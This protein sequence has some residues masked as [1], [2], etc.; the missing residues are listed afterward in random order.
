MTSLSE[1]T[2]I[3]Y[4]ERGRDRAGVDCWGVVCLVYR[5]RLEIDLPEYH[6]A[7][8]IAERAELGALIADQRQSGPWVTVDE[9]QAYDVAVISYEGHACH[10]GVWDGHGKILHAFAR[11]VVLVPPRRLPGHIL[12]TSRHVR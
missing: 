4:V 1:F 11:R 10:V 8:C 5:E 9:P 2:G 12:L 3:P 6:D 7:P